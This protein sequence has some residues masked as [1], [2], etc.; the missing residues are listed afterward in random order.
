MK[1]T[2]SLLILA[3]AAAFATPA[4][5]DCVY[6]KAPSQIPDGN[7][8]KLEEMV[9]ANKAVKAYNVEI[10]A[11][12]ACIQKEHDDK[13]AQGGD[14]LSEDQKKQMAVMLSQKNNAAVDELQA[15][16]AKVNEQ[17]RIYKAKSAK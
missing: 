12:L 6:P 8:A 7:T 2:S 17:I 11:Y 1:K 3:A 5:A 14:S 4:F 15:V 9:A 10:E 16:A 13:V